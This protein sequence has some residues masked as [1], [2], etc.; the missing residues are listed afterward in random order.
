MYVPMNDSDPRLDT[1]CH[2][3]VSPCHGTPRA[4]TSVEAIATAAGPGYRVRGRISSRMT[5]GAA[6]RRLT[7]ASRRSARASS[8]RCSR[9][10]RAARPLSA[11][12]CSGAGRAST[13]TK[14][15][16]PSAGRVRLDLGEG[17]RATGLALTI[18]IVGGCPEIRGFHPSGVPACRPRDAVAQTRRAGDPLCRGHNAPSASRSRCP[19]FGDLATKNGG[20]NHQ[21]SLGQ[22]MS[23]AIANRDLVSQP[24]VPSFMRQPS[25]A[26]APAT[27]EG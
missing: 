22:A 10:P 9:P 1:A 14:A 13:R 12:R 18:E 26:G 2:R 17:N 5:Y 7:S 11:W 3:I 25:G 8:G 24:Q 15:G 23:S 4:S 19:N 20:V 6:A 16:V 21:S 27:C